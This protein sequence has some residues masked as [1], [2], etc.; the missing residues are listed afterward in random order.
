MG[1]RINRNRPRNRSNSFKFLALSQRKP[2]IA[3]EMRWWR[4]NTLDASMD[5][6]FTYTLKRLMEFSAEDSFLTGEERDKTVDLFSHTLHMVH[7]MNKKCTT[8]NTICS[9]MQTWKSLCKF[10]IT[11]WKPPLMLKFSVIQCSTRPRCSLS[12]NTEG[13][14]LSH[15][16]KKTP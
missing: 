6:I 13:R 2:F 7:D 9:H 10:H 8:L 4:T 11:W 14:F 15:L 12:A 16:W 3:A 5:S 1:K